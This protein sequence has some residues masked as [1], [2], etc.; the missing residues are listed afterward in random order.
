M[1]CFNLPQRMIN[2]AK[3][4]CVIGVVS[5]VFSSC[6][7]KDVYDPANSG[8]KEEVTLD[9][10]FD[11]AT[12]KNIQLNIDYGKECPRAYFEVYAENPL[13]YVAEGGQI[14]KKAGVSHIATG[15]TDIQGRYIKPAS[16]P[17]AVSEVYIYSPDFGVPTLYKTKVVGSD[18]SA[19][20]TFENALDVTALDSS[21]RSA[22]TR[23]SLKFITNVIPNVLGTWNVNTGRPNYLDASKKI[24][25]DATLKSYIT[26]YFPE[27]KNNKGTLVSDDAD[28]LITKDANVVIN[29]FGGNTAAQSVFAY[30]CYPKDASVDE[31]REATKH[32]CV[33]FPNAHG[34]SLGYY[35]GVAV[36]LKY[37]SKDGKFPQ[38]DPERIP[39]DTRIGFLIWNNGWVNAK[40]NGNMFY[41]T[42]ALNSDGISHTAI[43]AAE[44]KAGERVNVITMEDWKNGENDYNDVA[45]VISS[46]PIAAIEV[47]DVPNPGD[48]QGT[49]KYSGVLGFED[50]WPEQGD[51]SHFHR[52]SSLP[53]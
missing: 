43:F 6:L 21:T 13:S 16:F 17:T 29:Y 31:M 40:A 2:I 51:Y 42:K 50:N 46:N 47:P 11:F 41:S 27:G 15:F 48:R 12:T 5:V 8:D 53:L 36:N 3:L 37:I 23:S 28:I 7:Q 33:I 30:Y 18:V 19:K 34:N 4:A 24:N 39:A 25:V 26:T 10:Y 35:S 22:Q 1:M 38:D 9:N 52:F 14:I 44:N 45:F 32:A 20:I 49:E